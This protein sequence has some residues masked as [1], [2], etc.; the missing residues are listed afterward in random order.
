MK[1][2]IYSPTETAFVS[3]GLGVLNDCM[4]CI[5]TEERNDEYELKLTYPIDGQHYDAIKQR[6]I[7]MAQ[8]RPDATPQPFRVY[9]ITRPISGKVTVYAQ[10][11]SYDLTRIVTGPFKATGIT[12]TLAGLKSNASTACPFDFWTDIDD[13]T[14]DF[15]NAAPSSIRSNIGGRNYSVLDMYGGEVEWDVYTVKVWKNRGADRGFTIRY[16]N[17]LIDLTQE[18]NCANVYTGVYP[19]WADNDGNLVTLAE[20]IVKAEGDFDFENVMPLDCSAEF[21]EAPTEDALREY[22]TNYIKKNK[23]GVPSVGFEVEF[24]KLSDTPEYAELKELEKIELCDTV[25]VIFMQLGVA[26]QA[27]VTRVEYDVLKERYTKITVGRVTR[28]IH[29][30]IAAQDSDINGNTSDIGKNETEIKK[31]VVYT[32]SQI[33]LINSKLE[34]IESDII[35][36][37]SYVDINNRTLYINPK[38][39]MGTKGT[40][41]GNYALYQGASTTVDLVHSVTFVQVVQILTYDLWRLWFCNGLFIG[42]TDPAWIFGDGGDIQE[43]DGN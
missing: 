6:A 37:T 22:T 4:S 16:G 27:T 24:A 43:W 35:V 19:Y 33:Q 10:H 5:V 1:P 38:G 9:R 20:K 18:E 41:G 40:V 39:E 17:N 21:N 30:L 42:Y 31:I 14:G 7:I 11:L 36:R 3:N 25:T 12:A 15:E 34:V 8:P 32:N 29:R 26:A 2:R 23:I 13:E 28:G